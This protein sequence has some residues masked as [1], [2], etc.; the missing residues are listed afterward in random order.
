MMKN[1]IAIIVS[2]V[3]S[4]IGVIIVRD[5]EPFGYDNPFLGPIVCTIGLVIAPIGLVIAPIVCTIGLVIALI[6]LRYFNR[7]LE[8]IEESIRKSIK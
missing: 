4:M 6:D 7:K 5:I 8:E 3:L 2:I 1:K